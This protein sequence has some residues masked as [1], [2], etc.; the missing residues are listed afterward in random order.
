[1]HYCDICNYQTSFSNNIKKHYNSQKHINNIVYNSI[2]NI[3]GYND[4]INDDINNEFICISCKKKYKYESGLK[5]HQMTCNHNDNNNLVNIKI[6][7]IK[8]DYEHKLE[9]EKLKNEYELKLKDQECELK[10]K[11]QEFETFKQLNSIVVNNNN[12]SNNQITNKITNNINISTLDFLNTN[13]C[14]VLDIDDF[15][16]N[17]KNDYGLNEEETKVLLENSELGGINNCIT[18]LSFYLQK[19]A[20]KMYKD[21]AGENIPVR[22]SVIPMSL[23]DTSI[24][25]HYEKNNSKWFRTSSMDKLSSIYNITNDQIYKHHQKHL[26]Y[27]GNQKKKIQNGLLKANDCSKLINLK[28]K[29]FYKKKPT[30]IFNK[31]NQIDEEKEKEEV[32]V[33]EEEVKVNEEEVNEEEVNEEEVNDNEESDYGYNDSDDD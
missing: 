15:I 14:N 10:L 30:I 27:D 12:N 31:Q 2:I 33:N 19:S 21:F 20:N 22:E 18:T 5:K 25:S 28:S 6:N 23:V 29:E 7:E 8:K 13:F 24:R 11:T 17:Y 26:S 4:D 1:M 9:I 32:K 3:D 16:E